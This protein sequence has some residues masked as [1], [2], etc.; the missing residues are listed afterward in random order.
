ML[1]KYYKNI[2]IYS[3]SSFAKPDGEWNMWGMTQTKTYNFTGRMNQDTCHWLKLAVNKF[4]GL[5]PYSG[6]TALASWNTHR[7]FPQKQISPRFLLSLGHDVT[8]NNTW[9]KLAGLGSCLA[10]LQFY[11]NVSNVT[12]VC[13][14]AADVYTRCGQL[15]KFQGLYFGRQ[16][17]QET[18]INKDKYFF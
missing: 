16:P 4:N 13:N 7:H 9:K 2:Q 14:P 6:S 1:M 12:A 11:K 10:D 15:A 3:W 5:S 17:R 8:I 18:C